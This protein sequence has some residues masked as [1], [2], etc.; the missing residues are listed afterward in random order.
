LNYLILIGR[1]DLLWLHAVLTPCS[2]DSKS[3]NLKVK[4]YTI[5]EHRKKN[6]FEKSLSYWYSLSGP[7]VSTIARTWVKLSIFKTALHHTQFNYGYRSS[8]SSL[9]IHVSV[10]YALH[11][12]QTVHDWRNWQLN[13]FYFQNNHNW[14]M[15]YSLSNH[16]P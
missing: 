6:K 9:P 1:S 13:T 15:W 7:I 11:Q 10:L 5:E 12:L 8:K 3:M 16:T 14:I 2:F 4:M